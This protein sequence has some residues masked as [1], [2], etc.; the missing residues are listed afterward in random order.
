MLSMF[1]YLFTRAV[2]SAWFTNQKHMTE[3]FTTGG[4]L[5][6]QLEYECILKLAETMPISYQREA[7]K[8]QSILIRTNLFLKHNTKQ[9]DSGFAEEIKDIGG[10]KEKAVLLENY[11]YLKEI[12]EETQGKVLTCEGTVVTAPYCYLS[13]GSMRNGEELSYLEAVESPYDLSSP[14]YLKLSLFSWN[15]LEDQFRQNLYALCLTEKAS[16]AAIDFSVEEEE[17]LPFDSTKTLEE[18][19]KEQLEVL[20]REE[21]GYVK[22]VRLGSYLMSGE[23]FRNMFGL[24]SSDFYVDVLANSQETG[25]EE[26]QEQEEKTE[27]KAEEKVEE[28]TEE[29][30]QERIRMVTRGCGH[31][32][33]MSQYGAECLA[34]EGKTGEEILKIYFPKLEIKTL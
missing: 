33:G 7:L 13:A 20:E 16:D 15:E 25:T 6:R 24:S 12:T 29:K 27:K 11:R 3:D 8:A 4:D 14:E 34:R 1:P 2:D 10:R 21:S 26:E 28:K 22:K 31:G 32:Y 18:N 23:E 30:E 9:E 19:V 17:L 5:S